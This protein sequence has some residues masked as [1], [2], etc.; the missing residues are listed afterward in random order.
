MFYIIP[1]KEVYNRIK[2]FLTK[3]IDVYVFENSKSNLNLIDKNLY[4]IGNKT[5]QGIGLALKK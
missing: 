5:N 4:Y 1:Q 3:K 2:M